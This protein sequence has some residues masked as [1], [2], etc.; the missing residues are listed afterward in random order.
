M[1]SAFSYISQTQSPHRVLEPD[2]AGR[3]YIDVSQGVRVRFHDFRRRLIMVDGMQSDAVTRMTSPATSRTRPLSNTIPPDEVLFGRSAAMSEVRGRAEKISNTNI[4]VLLCG[5]GGTGKEALARWIHAQSGY[6]QG[7]FVKVNCA[8]IPGNLLESELFGY[9]KGAFTGAHLS[10]P[11]RVEL[12]HNGTLFLDE[13]ADLEMA[14][15][16]KILHFL[17]D[18]CFSRIGDQTERAVNVRVICATNKDLEQ[19]IAAGNFR[20]DLFYRINVVRFRLPRLRDRKEDIPVLAEYFRILH[21]QDFATASAPLDAATIEYLQNSNWPG[22]VRELSNGMARHVLIGPEAL[23]GPAPLRERVT[24]RSV[25]RGA[26][27]EVPLK[28]IA[29]AA[30]QELERN[31]ILESLRTHQW[32]RRKTAAALQISYRA[33]IYKIRDAGLTS[34]RPVRTQAR[35]LE[36]S[37]S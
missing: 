30:I 25:V 7:E 31:V 36:P 2:A 28:R 33:L 6:R 27:G 10:K 17:Q 11:G 13:I 26:V 19:A 20:E 4:P 21:E 32:N 18:G 24:A 9:E 1:F 14:L 37:Q 12:A 8:A 34:R 3:I 22:N 16:S 5:E 23:A 35:A 29:K 15:Q